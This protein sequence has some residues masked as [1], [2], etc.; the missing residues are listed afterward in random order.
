[1]TFLFAQLIAFIPVSSDIVPQPFLHL[2]FVGLVAVFGEQTFR[3]QHQL[4]EVG[5]S[6]DV[7]L[8]AGLRAIVCPSASPK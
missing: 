6:L 4:L 3:F 2:T 5:A 8:A 1:M 7:F